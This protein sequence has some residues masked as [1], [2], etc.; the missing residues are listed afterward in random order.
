[1]GDPIEARA[2]HNVFSEGRTPKN[3]LQLGSVKSNVG[4]LEN[5]SGVIAV[6][7]AAMMLEKGFILPNTNFKT[8]NENIPLAAWNMKVCGTISPW[9]V[10]SHLSRTST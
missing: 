1:M 4:H 6:I 3:P 8:P 9:L 2:I 5:A 7:K 10:S